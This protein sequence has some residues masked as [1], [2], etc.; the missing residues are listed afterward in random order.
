[1]ASTTKTYTIDASGRTVGRIA[2]EAAK[3]LMGKT[4]AQYTPH[5]R[6]DVK[7]SIINAS[8]VYSR[9]RK[10]VQTFHTSYSGYPGGLKRESLQALGKRKGNSEILRRA[11]RRMLPRNTMLTARLKNLTISE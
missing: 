4:S 9:E 2:S 8:K 10:L 7:V 3:A 11:V 6:S 1:M 5:I